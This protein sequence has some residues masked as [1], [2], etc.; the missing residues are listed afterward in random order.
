LNEF[1]TEQTANNSSRP[2][3]PQQKWGRIYLLVAASAVAT[4]VLLHAFSTYFAS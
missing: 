3:P 1:M 2:T 4:V